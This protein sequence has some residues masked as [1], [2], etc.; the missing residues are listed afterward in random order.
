MGYVHQLYWN[1]AGCG[2][3]RYPLYGLLILW[4]TSRA[5]CIWGVETTECWVERGLQTNV[6]NSIET[7]PQNFSD[8]DFILFCMPNA[9]CVSVNSICFFC[10]KIK[11]LFV[12]FH[13]AREI[14]HVWRFSWKFLWT[15]FLTRI[16]SSNSRWLKRLKLLIFNEQ[17]RWPLN[18]LIIL[19]IFYCLV[20]RLQP[21]NWSSY[22]SFAKLKRS[23]RHT[24][25]EISEGTYSAGC[26]PQC[27][28]IY[29]NTDG[30][31]RERWRKPQFYE[32]SARAIN[33][34]V[35]TTECWYREVYETNVNNSIFREI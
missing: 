3:C 9:K 5:M 13:V 1:T 32:Y 24:W 29:G 35:E 34:G 22:S 10:E 15:D 25:I 30:C 21:L 33:W 7:L 17:I 14:I 2:T 28:S 8:W 23:E 20:N 16:I 27:T 19:K 11:R 12:E 18:C 4:H 6:N 31:G 26:G